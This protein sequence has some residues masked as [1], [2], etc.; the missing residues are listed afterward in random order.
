MKMWDYEKDVP[1]YRTLFP[2]NEGLFHYLLSVH[3]LPEE[4]MNTFQETENVD[5]ILDTMCFTEFGQRYVSANVM[6][7]YDLPEWEL[8][9]PFS[10]KMMVAELIYHLFYEKWKSLAKVSFL[11][12][13][14]IHN[15]S[16]DLHEE[17]VGTEDE[18]TTDDI[19]KST[20][21]NESRN[22]INTHNDNSNGTRT[23][24][25]TQQNLRNDNL[26]EQRGDNHA[27]SYANSDS[28]NLYG[29]NSTNPVGHDTSGGTS[30]DNGTE[31][32][33]KDQTGTQTNTR[34]DNLQETHND[35]NIGQS[36]QGGS[37]NSNETA[38]DDR[39]EVRDLDTTRVRDVTRTGNI[40]NITTQAMIEEEIR[41]RRWTFMMQLVSDVR[42]FCTL[43]IYVC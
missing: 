20:Y 35:V 38:T 29:F 34:T 28:N 4:F 22:L 11:E 10:G 7:Y 2:P 13:D 17:I 32:H 18:T 23:N 42:E 25:G 9:S 30:S 33:S 6:S 1:K 14:P 3:E 12:Y 31:S 16:D 21:K 40:G 26:H 43:P 36:T 39:E 24:S 27:F 15:F 37:I 5:V 8:P 19:D 41:L